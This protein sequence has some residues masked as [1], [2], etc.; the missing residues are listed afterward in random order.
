[1]GVYWLQVWVNDTYGNVQTA[2]LSV[3]VQDTTPP[4]WGIYPED[5]IVEFGFF[6][7]YHLEAWDLSGVDQWWLNDTVNFTID[8]NDH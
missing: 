4:N 6:L 3:I 1:V 2:T 5:K 7:F 8:Q